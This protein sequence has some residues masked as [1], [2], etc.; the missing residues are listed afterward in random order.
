MLTVYLFAVPGY[1]GG[2]L[3]SNAA[4]E[5]LV[6][7]CRDERKTLFGILLVY[8]GAQMGGLKY[9]DLEVAT[10]FSLYRL[11]VYSVVPLPSS[12]SGPNV[13]LSSVSLDT[14]V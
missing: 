14:R 7:S 2:S 4:L 13:H 6:L 3:L 5:I 9:I 1:R 10:H 12:S 8:V 11:N